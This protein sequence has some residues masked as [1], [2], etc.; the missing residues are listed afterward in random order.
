MK[1]V[2]VDLLVIGNLLVINNL[3]GG[4]VKSSNWNCYADESL[5]EA[6]RVVHGDY[7]IDG[8]SDMSIA[9]TGGIT[10]IRKEV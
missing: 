2:K 1:K 3:R 6:D 4:W 8:D 10:I 5:Y 7:E 9:V